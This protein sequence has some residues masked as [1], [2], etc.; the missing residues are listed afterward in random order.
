MRGPM[1]VHE[2]MQECLT[3]AHFGYYMKKRAIG[4]RGDFIT[5]P[6]IS[7]MFGELVGVWLVAMWEKLGSPSDF[8]LIE[9]GPGTGSMLSDVLRVCCESIVVA[10]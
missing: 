10:R 2:Y 4:Q 5:S 7:Q 3:N 8:R 9:L 6:E 1:T